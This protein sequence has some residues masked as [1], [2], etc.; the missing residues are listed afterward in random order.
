LIYLHAA[1]TGVSLGV[2]NYC[3]RPAPVANRIVI[4]R[5]T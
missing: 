3:R 4:Q 2:A 5:C 1:A